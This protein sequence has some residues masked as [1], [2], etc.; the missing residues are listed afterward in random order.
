VPLLILP[1]DHD[2]EAG[3]LDDFRQ[4][5]TPKTF[6]RV[7][8]IGETAVILLDIVSAGSGGPDFR[9]GHAQSRWLRNTLS[10]SAK[11]IVVF[12]HAFPG[13]LKDGANEIVRLF[14]D[15]GV[16]YVGTGRTHYNDILN[17]GHVIYGATR[18]TGEIEE[19]PAGYS[20]SAL[21]G[22]VIS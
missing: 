4:I 9:L 21:D 16:A 5:L 8:T 14:A 17:D 1:G 2:F 20:I 22:D 10:G 15:A 3:H 12:M 6:P 18:S 11:P 19:G 7:E 13:D